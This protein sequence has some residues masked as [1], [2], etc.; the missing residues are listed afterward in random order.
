MLGDLTAPPL[1]ERAKDD[2]DTCS[3]TYVT[4]RV[5]H[6]A[7]DPETVGKILGLVATKTQRPGQEYQ[8]RQGVRT[9]Q[10]SGWF[11]CSEHHV[12]SFDTAKHLAWL[13][14]QLDGRV[15]LLA[16]LKQAGWWMD[17]F[18]MWDSQYGHG[19]P[20]LPASLLGR[21]ASLG[22]DL[23]FDVYFFG[24]YRGL[25]EEAARHAWKGT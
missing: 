17:I 4:L 12:Q 25:R 11:L 16:E 15:Q 24:A 21:L 14:D 5:Y 19:G 7:A 13:L 23:G 6:R 1:P 20:T 9:Y 8:H 2:Y 3:D 10:I 18:C 22:I